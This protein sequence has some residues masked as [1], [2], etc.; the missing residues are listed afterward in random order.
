MDF[1]LE[2]GRVR[3]R[4]LRPADL[5]DFAAYRADPNVARFQG[6]DPYIEAE[7]A[8]F[9]AEQAGEAVPAV[10]GSWVQLAIAR[11]DDDQL[12]GDCAL[13]RYAHEPRFGEIGITLA[14][15]WQGQGY[16]QAALR[17]LLR[18]CFAELS[19]HRMLALA[20]TRNLPCVALLESV[21][22]RREGHF[23]HNGWYKGEWCDEYQYALLASEWAAPR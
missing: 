19:M 7:A 17:G 3:L 23:R 14:P 21:G 5:P 13:H 10:P 11:A 22:L 1:S 18:Y 2:A 4:N 15:R 16:A 8:D 20:D 9:I 12:L 6:F